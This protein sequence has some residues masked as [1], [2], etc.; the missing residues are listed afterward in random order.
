[1]GR[2]RD[3][4]ADWLL[5]GRYGG[6]PDENPDWVFDLSHVRDRVLDN[7]GLEPGQTLLDVGAGDGLIAFG[8]LER[9]AAEVIFSDVSEDLLEHSRRRADELGLTDRC[10]FVHASAD[11]LAGVA[12]ESIDALTTRSV[13]IYVEPKRAAF[14]EFSRVVRPGGRISLF[15]PINRFGA[16]FRVEE[17]LWGY[18]LDGLHEIIA[19]VNAHFAAIQPDTDPMLDF[20][21]RDLVALAEGAGFF[22]V[23]LDLHLAIKPVEPRPWSRFVA[24]AGNPKIPTLAEAMDEV[25]TPAERQRVTERLRPHVERGQGVERSA[26]A[27]LRATKP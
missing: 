13:L 1:M 12:D 27:Y 14:A 22:P 8:A 24:T 5:R 16:R 25:L 2:P 7:A 6:D 21:E 19:K 11:D 4:W 10:R 17:S 18:P 15:E 26:V 9:G 20:D 23:E 3:R